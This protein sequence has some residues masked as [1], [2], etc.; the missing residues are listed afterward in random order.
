MVYLETER[1]TLR[2]L[3]SADAEHLIALDSDPEVM[4]YLTNGVP[5]PPDTIIHQ[6]LPRLLGWYH[7]GDA[8]G[9]WAAIARDSGDFLGWFHF[10]PPNDAVEGIEVGYRLKQAAWGQGYATEGTRAIIRK[11]FE[12][13]GVTRVIAKTLSANAASRRV[14]EKSGMAYVETFTE[15]R[16]DPP[17]EAVWYAIE[18]PV[19]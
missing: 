12:E 3:T 10:R 4:R 11:A 15:Y 19:A 8:Y 13:L 18:K 7:Q 9:F 1:L 17:Q 2:Q 6:M 5:T 14:M 16:I